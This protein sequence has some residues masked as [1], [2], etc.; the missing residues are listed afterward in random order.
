MPLSKE[1][2]PRMSATQEWKPR[3]GQKLDGELQSTE[4]RLLRLT[5]LVSNMLQ[6]F[7]VSSASSHCLQR[8]ATCRTLGGDAAAVW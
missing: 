7:S 1:K 2:Q 8:W 4:E 5:F 6:F 3:E